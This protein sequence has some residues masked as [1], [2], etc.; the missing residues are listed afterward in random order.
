MLVSLAM[1]SVGASLL[2][3][4]PIVIAHRGASGYRPEHTIEAYRLGIEQGADYI[5]PDLVITKDGVL[6][7][8]HENKLDDSTDVAQKPE[9]ESR[10]TT[11]QIDGQTVTGWFSEDFTLAEIKTLRARERLPMIRRANT[12]FNGQFEIPTFAEVIEFAQS[13]SKRLNRTI[14][15]YP[16]TKHPSYFRSI[17]RPLEEPLLRNLKAAG[18]DTLGSPVYIQSFEVGNLKDLKSKTALPLIQLVDEEG[19]PADQ[20][21]TYA[22]MLTSAGL[23]DIRTYAVGIGAAKNLVIPRRADG[24]LGEPTSLVKNAR[25]AGL[26]I[27]VWTFRSEAIFLPKGTDAQPEKEL[28]AFAKAGIDGFFTDHPDIAVK[29][30]RK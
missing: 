25:Q 16:E 8:R 9:F 2:Q 3:T 1:L 22:S 21:F 28:A 11:K 14:G 23:T 27:H 7:A 17:Q 30:L 20:K 12:A 4:S 15:V 18:W 13:E 6:I 29:T 10:K 19:S 24:S 5:E 26:L